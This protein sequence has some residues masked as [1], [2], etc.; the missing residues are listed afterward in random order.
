M[1]DNAQEDPKAPEDKRELSDREKAELKAVDD[2]YAKKDTAESAKR[3]LG[4][5]DDKETEKKEVDDM[6]K[7]QKKKDDAEKKKRSLGGDV[8]KTEKNDDKKRVLK[9]AAKPEATKRRLTDST[10]VSANVAGSRNR[11]LQAVEDKRTILTPSQPKNL[12]FPSD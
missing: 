11:V 12:E 10:N 8:V 5:D 7:K 6:D 9:E 4:D 2:K 1:G 3:N